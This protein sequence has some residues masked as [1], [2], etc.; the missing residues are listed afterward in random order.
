MTESSRVSCS[1]CC[2][3]KL[4]QEIYNLIGESV[5][6]SISFNVKNLSKPDMPVNISHIP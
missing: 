2:T 3:S 1:I 4:L 6:V 5:A